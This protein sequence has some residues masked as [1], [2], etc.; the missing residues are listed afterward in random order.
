MNVTSYHLSK[1]WDQ[2]HCSHCAALCSCPWQE[3]QGCYGGHYRGRVLS[4][5]ARI[6]EGLELGKRF[7]AALVGIIGGGHSPSSQESLSVLN[8]HVMN[9]L[10]SKIRKWYQEIVECWTTRS[11]ARSRERIEMSRSTKVE[12]CAKVLVE[13][14]QNSFRNSHCFGYHS[15]C[16]PDSI[17]LVHMLTVAV[18]NL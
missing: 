17:K 9:R 15:S 2:H 18:T 11:Y 6:T 16:C 8:I 7:R 1:I 14:L 10:F 13:R 4:F 12:S 5:L 3:I